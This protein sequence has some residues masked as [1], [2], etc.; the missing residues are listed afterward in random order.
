MSTMQFPRCT[1]K[2]QLFQRVSASLKLYYGPSPRLEFSKQ[3]IMK[4]REDCLL[5]RFGLFEK[6]I[7]TRLR[8]G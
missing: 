2:T 3:K 1:E 8:F 4:D 5:T 7:T 6:T